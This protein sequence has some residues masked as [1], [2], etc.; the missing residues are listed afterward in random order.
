MGLLDFLGFAND[1]AAIQSSTNGTAGVS[2]SAPAQDSIQEKI[3]SATSF[4]GEYAASEVVGAIARNALTQ[5]AILEKKRG[6]L[7]DIIAGRFGSTSL[8]YSKFA[9]AVEATASVIADNIAEVARRIGVFDIDEYRRVRYYQAS[10]V[11]SNDPLLDAKWEL[12]SSSREAMVEILDA[13]ENLLLELEKFAV[14]I[15]QDGEDVQAK[16][17]AMVEEIRK[18]TSEL[19]FYRSV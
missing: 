4:L 9:S 16:S 1:D 6:V 5:L 17:D 2:T 13:N 12:F 3:D 18:L 19:E 7:L 10:G 8:T 14:E 11:E 15:G